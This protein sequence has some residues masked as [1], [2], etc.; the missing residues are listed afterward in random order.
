[1]ARAA[2]KGELMAKITNLLLLSSRLRGPAYL[3]RLADLLGHPQLRSETCQAWR[4]DQETVVKRPPA[5]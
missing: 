2:E 3:G 5:C 4:N 1:M